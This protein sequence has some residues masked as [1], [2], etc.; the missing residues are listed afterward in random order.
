MI[1]QV[2]LS[3][4]SYLARQ[5]HG[6]EPVNDLYNKEKSTFTPPEVH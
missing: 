6:F 2:I 3:S 5:R 1:D 4:V